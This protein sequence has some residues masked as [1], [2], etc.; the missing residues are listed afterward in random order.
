[1]AVERTSIGS[2]EP[3]V[4][5]AA[6]SLVS[7]NKVVAVV[8]AS[9]VSG[10]NWSFVGHALAHLWHLFLLKVGFVILLF[11]QLVNLLLCLLVQ[12]L[13][14]GVLLVLIKEVRSSKSNKL[15]TFVR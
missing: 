7:H 1:M 13:A 9:A 3:V 8:T 11:K 5:G 12:L 6:V 10:N 4:S 15:H 14:I 2:G